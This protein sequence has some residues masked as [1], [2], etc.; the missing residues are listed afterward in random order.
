MERR[1]RRHVEDD[2]RREEI[3]YHPESCL[4]RRQVTTFSCENKTEGR[5][6]KEKKKSHMTEIFVY[7]AYFT[8]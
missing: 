6:E 2:G 4:F 5:P 8:S 3:L 1:N 7:C